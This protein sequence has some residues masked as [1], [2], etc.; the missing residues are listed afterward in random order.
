MFSF[1]MC[2]SVKH[3]M[4]KIIFLVHYIELAAKLLFYPCYL[5]YL[6]LS[7]DCLLTLHLATEGASCFYFIIYNFTTV[8][9]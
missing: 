2:T 3:N 7:A 1:W 4:K 6:V 9:R 5:V 8:M